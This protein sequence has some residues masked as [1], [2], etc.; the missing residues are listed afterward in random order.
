MTVACDAG[1]RQAVE[2]WIVEAGQRHPSV[3]DERLEVAE[4]F[5]VRNVPAGFWIDE[6]GRI[7]RANDPIYAYV[8][9]RKT[10]E[11]TT[12]RVYLDAV[13]DWVANGPESASLMDEARLSS[14]LP[15]LNADHVQAAA[16]FHLAIYLAQHGHAEDALVHFK[17]AH[18]LRP[19]NWTYRRQAW[20]L[21]HIERDYGITIMEAVTDPVGAP[22]YPP[23]ELGP[24]TQ[25]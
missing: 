2:R 8:K 12:N 7:L 24:P 23:L 18:A 10:D 21:G 4:R 19:E 14:R 13:R 17:R 3:L 5:D 22:F 1:G 11:I 9:E 25:S 6:K 20:T 15:S 16:S